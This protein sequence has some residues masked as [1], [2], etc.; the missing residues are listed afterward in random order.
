MDDFRGLDFL[1]E[2]IV[3]FGPFKWFWCREELLNP[4][5]PKDE[6]PY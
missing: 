4:V 2:S 3:Y 6:S 5:Q 1:G